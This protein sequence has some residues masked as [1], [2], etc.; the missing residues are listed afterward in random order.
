MEDLKTTDQSRV[1]RLLK[2]A[3]YDRQTA[4]D[5]LDRQP[6]C[7]VGYVIDGRPYVTPTLQWRS[8]DR[9]I[10][11]GS[12][13]SRALR[14]GSGADV[15]LTVSVLDGFVM[16]RSG[17]NHSVNA[18]SLVLFGRAG[19]V[20]EAEKATELDAFV[21]RLWPGRSAI[22]RPTT[23][24]E[25]KATTLLS[26]QIDEGSLKIRTGPPCDEPEDYDLPIWA[27]VIPLRTAVDPAVADPVNREGVDMPDHIRDFAWPDNRLGR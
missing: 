9:V 14:A 21:D 5:L 1:R 17:Y 16:A 4:Y 27:G 15:C 3:S 6:M 24:Q 13:A 22:L 25:L 10:W 7:S 20:P 18:R 19:I 11:H 2:N 26:M 23:A 12:S 8:G